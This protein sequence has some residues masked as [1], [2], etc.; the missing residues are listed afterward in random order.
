MLKSVQIHKVVRVTVGAKI[1]VRIRAR[2]TGHCNELNDY[3]LLGK[4]I[5]R[6]DKIIVYSN[7]ASYKGAILVVT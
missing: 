2:V 4:H 5:L 6:K 1:R 3:Q 7:Q